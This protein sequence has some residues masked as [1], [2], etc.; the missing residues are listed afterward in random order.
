M[1]QR[2]L[3]RHSLTVFNGK[4]RTILVPTPASYT[5]LHRAFGKIWGLR[6]HINGCLTRRALRIVFERNNHSSRTHRVASGIWKKNWPGPPECPYQLYALAKFHPRPMPRF[7]WAFCFLSRRCSIGHLEKN[8]GPGH[9]AECH[10]GIISSEADA[11]ILPGIF[12]GQPRLSRL[13]VK[14]RARFSGENRG[15]HCA[16]GVPPACY[17]NCLIMSLMAVYEPLLCFRDRH[18]GW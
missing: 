14:S 8:W 10:I 12:A 18:R 11:A 16:H 1:F 7:C 2:P 5:E 13:G 9:S 15:V 17:M 3:P 4:E 6:F